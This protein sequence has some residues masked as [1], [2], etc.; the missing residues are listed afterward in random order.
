MDSQELISFFNNNDTYAQ[1]LGINVVDIKPGYAKAYLDIKDHHKNGLRITHGGAIFSLAD[2]TFAAASNSY[3][4]PAVAI[5]ANISFLKAGTNGRVTA[6]AFENS[7]GTKLASYTINVTNEQGEICAIFQG[8]V[9][10]KQGIIKFEEN[11][12]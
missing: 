3:G 7:C 10:R 5:N 2:I 8:M 4:H 11:A 12:F 6:E 1:Y 9:Y